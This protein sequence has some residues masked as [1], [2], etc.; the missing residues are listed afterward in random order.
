MSTILAKQSSPVR[1]ALNIVG[2]A[3]TAVFRQVLTYGEPNL[4]RQINSHRSCLK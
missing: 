1:K 2:R 3:T 4:Y